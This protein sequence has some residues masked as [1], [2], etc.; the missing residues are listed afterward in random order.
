M[1]YQRN[2][3]LMK[4]SH[5]V[6]QRYTF[7]QACLENVRIRHYSFESGEREVFEDCRNDRI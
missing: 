1:L 4:F 6:K 2:V 3:S 5:A 7:R